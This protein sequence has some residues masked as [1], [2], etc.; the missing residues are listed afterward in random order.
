MQKLLIN[1]ILIV[2]I[3]ATT[4]KTKFLRILRYRIYNFLHRVYA[5]MPESFF[6]RRNTV[7]TARLFG[8][9]DGCGLLPDGYKKRRLSRAIMGASG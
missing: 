1:Q 2:L 6:K 7:K 8:A 9:S 5:R 4:S 3:T